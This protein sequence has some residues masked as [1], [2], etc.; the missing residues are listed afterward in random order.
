[1]SDMWRDP[2]TRRWVCDMR[3]LGIVPLFVAAFLQ[4]AAPGSASEHEAIRGRVIDG[5]TGAPRGRVAVILVIAQ[6]S[7]QDLVRTRTDARG[8]F[9]FSDLVP[10]EEASYVLVARYEGGFFARGPFSPSSDESL[11]KVSISVWDTTTDPTVISVKR[12]AIFVVPDRGEVSVLESLVVKNESGRAYIGRG[13]ADRRDGWADP[14]LG[15]GLPSQAE[16]RDVQILESSIPILNVVPADFGAAV[17][18]AIPPGETRITFAYRLPG[19]IGSYDLSRTALYA[20]GEVAVYA[21][22]PFEISSNRLARSS[23]ERIGGTSY[24]VWSSQGSIEAGDPIQV[25]ATAEAGAEPA[26]IGGI[27]AGSLVVLL[28]MFFGVRRL[29]KRRRRP[30]SGATALDQSPS[31]RSDVVAAIAQVDV[32]YRNSEIS[33]ADWRRIRAELKADLAGR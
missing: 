8:R 4:A 27:A 23:S 32:S 2:Q 1:M 33:E 18:S 17:T 26:V 9:F 19:L 31:T 10:G 21:A 28:G 15:L 20:T 29:L 11:R 14:T 12:D 7:G 22:D 25:R 5:A 24:R 16:S 6:A 30:R 3:R 13:N